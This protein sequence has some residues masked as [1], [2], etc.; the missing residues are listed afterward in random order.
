MGLFDNL[1]YLESKNSLV[2]IDSSFALMLA[3]FL[4]KDKN[5]YKYALTL[6]FATICHI[7]IIS[8]LKTESYGF[9]YTWYDELVAIAMLSQIWISKSGITTALRNLQRLLR[10]RNVDRNSYNKDISIQEKPKV[11]T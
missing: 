10:G 9:F 4:Y 8:S 6:C 2:L 11:K 3:M 1:S 7:M 5:A